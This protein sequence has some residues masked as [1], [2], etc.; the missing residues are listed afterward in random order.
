[1]MLERPR[2]YHCDCI[3]FIMTSWYWVRGCSIPNILCFV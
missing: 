2:L 1:M 3:V